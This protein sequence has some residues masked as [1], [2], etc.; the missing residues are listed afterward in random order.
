[1]VELRNVKDP[2]YP[3]GMVVNVM[4]S[5]VDEMTSSGLWERV[6]NAVVVKKIRGVRS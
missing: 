1:M 5:R 4:S 6:D 3:G 2:H